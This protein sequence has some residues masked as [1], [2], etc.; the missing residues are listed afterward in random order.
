MTDVETLPEEI[1]V[2][3]LKAKAERSERSWR[4]NSWTGEFRD[5]AMERA[6]L[7]KNQLSIARQMRGALAVWAGLVLVFLLAD[8][9]ALIGSAS[10]WSSAAI[11]FGVV[12]VL[13]F[14]SWQIKRKPM[15]ATQARWISLLE[16][17][18]MTC[19]LAVYVFR[20]EVA[21][22]AFT[23][24]L[25][26]LV[27]TFVYIPNRIPAILG[28][29]TYMGV[30]TVIMLY[31]VDSLAPSQIVGISIVTLMPIGLGWGT[32]ARTQILQ[33]RQFALW[34]QAQEVNATLSR[35]IEERARLQAA[36][37]QQ[38]TTD[39]LTG[40][41]NRRQYESLFQYELNRSLRTGQP[42]TLCI[43]DL[44]H[45]KQI[46]DTWG[47]STGD[48]VLKRVGQLCR[49]SFRATDILGRLGGE[50]F[51]ALLP[52]T[53]LSAALLVAQRFVDKL[54]ASTISEEVPQLRVTATVGVAQLGDERRLDLLLQRADKALY[55]GKNAG[56]N[57]VVAG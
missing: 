15:L 34:Q 12:A 44:D 25:I 30:S 40:L 22:W 29:T 26:M 42:L 28:V 18:G 2:Q 48:E 56:R 13:V 54:A 39:A 33:R 10:F 5:P 50:E 4:I 37:V 3:A 38:A 7:E 14:F 46:N 51:V 8:L 36:L 47:H 23:L 11:R 24:T 9:E 21:H 55:A 32:A 20:P 19:F 17:M 1:A 31:H 41:N 53:D 45:F 27:T 35:E 16:V 52:E 57:Q 43:I 49:D 6:Y